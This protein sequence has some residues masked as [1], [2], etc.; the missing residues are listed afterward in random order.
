M[1]IV[2]IPW[3]G[4][5]QK[6][7]KEAT[8][9]PP[10][11]EVSSDQLRQWSGEQDTRFGSALLANND[12]LWISA[13]EDC[14]TTLYTVDN[15]TLAPVSGFQQCGVQE[16]HDLIQG[17]DA[18]WVYTPLP[19]PTWVDQNANRIA[20]RRIAWQRDE[21]YWSTGQSIQNIDQNWELEHSL[22]DLTAY[23]QSIV[24]LLNDTPQQLWVLE[25]NEPV[26]IPFSN[27]SEFSTIHGLRYEDTHLLVLGGGQTLWFGEPDSLE[28]LVIPED[29]ALGTD[30]PYHPHISIGY[31]SVLTDI[32][33]DEQLDL[34]VGAPTAGAGFTN[35]FFEHAGWVGWF[36]QKNS[37]W[38]W[39]RE[40][41]GP[42]AF[43]HFGWQLAVID[44]D[45]RHTVVVGAPG[46][47]RVLEILAFEPIPT[48]SP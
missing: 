20:A 38:I 2:L 1:I 12:T 30:L 36:E 13:P 3:L 16:G 35:G 18:P 31:S 26:T 17:P 19:T 7:E 44:T 46:A 10:R 22:Q 8:I 42:E 32:D 14:N 37:A 45:Q 21:F 34:F 5:K 27:K 29:S 28:Q 15:Q 23:D 6:N 48:V 25:T 41:V 9:D 33:G 40:W 24:A 4:C 47:N 43:A 39:Q 11:V